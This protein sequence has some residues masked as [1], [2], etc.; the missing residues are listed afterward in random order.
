MEIFY[1]RSIWLKCSASPASWCTWTAS[2]IFFFFNI[3][4]NCVLSNFSKMTALVQIPAPATVILQG[5]VIRCL[6]CYLLP[7]NLPFNNSLVYSH[8][9][10][11]FSKWSQRLLDQ[12]RLHQLHGQLESVLFQWAVDL[13]FESMSCVQAPY[14]FMGKPLLKAFGR[15]KL[16][17]S[18]SIKEDL[19]LNIRME[20]VETS[21][22]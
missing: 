11:W 13:V 5:R 1:R 3:Q 15:F 20:V 21:T 22:I 4:S 17:S 6:R 12:A 19:M 7:N 2:L 9:K 18:H 10:T 14:L 16:R 8:A